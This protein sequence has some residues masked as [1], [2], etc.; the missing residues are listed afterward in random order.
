MRYQEL[1]AVKLGRHQK[2]EKYAIFVDTATF[3][4]ALG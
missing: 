2:V 4:K 3:P 1:K